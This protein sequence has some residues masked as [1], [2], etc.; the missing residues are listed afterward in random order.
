MR[1]NY[2]FICA[3]LLALVLIAGCKSASNIKSDEA[4]NFQTEIDA[5]LGENM[6]GILV[7]VATKNHSTYNIWTGAAGLSDWRSNV[8]MQPD[9]TFRIASVTKTFVAATI[10]KLWEDG[11]LQLTDPIEKYI[12]DEHARILKLGGYNPHEITIY[13]LLTHSSGMSEHTHG[14]RYKIDYM[15]TNHVWTRTE[16]LQDLVKYAHP[17]GAIG[18]KF[19][20]SD[21]G[22]ILLG[23]IIEA[24]THK[25]M[26]ESIVEQLSL[27]QLGL[28]SIYF[29]DITGDF[30][31]RRIHQYYKNEDTYHINP[32]LDYYGG[33]GLLANTHDLALFFQYLFENRIFKNKATLD[34][35]LAPVSFASKQ[36]LDYRM[37]LWQIEVCGLTAYTHSGFW[38]TQLV[39]IPNL[40]TSIAV[41]YSQL[42]TTRGVAPIVPIIVEKLVKNLPKSQ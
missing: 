2:C 21:S 36:T 5:Q 41:N 38:G 34:Q 39:Y 6:P 16:Q 33:G 29:E 35:M 10:L 19:S 3:Q 8:P 11:K 13:H 42:W 17:V 37:G 26:G 15:L 4:I 32:S 9:Q 28:T 7:G 22:Y 23:E 14:D 27:V 12:S 25:T 30:S 31:G 18:E 1:K 40:E 24:I 20:Y